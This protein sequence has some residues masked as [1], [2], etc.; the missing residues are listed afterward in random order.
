MLV[1]SR[2]IFN[3]DPSVALD[4]LRS[5]GLIAADRQST[6]KFL[7]HTRI[8]DRSAMGKLLAAE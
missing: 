1:Q 6:T 5:A 2:R 7:L 3:A 8:L 4:V